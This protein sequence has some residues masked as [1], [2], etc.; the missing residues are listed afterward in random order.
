MASSDPRQKKSFTRLVS[1][2]YNRT[3]TGATTQ[4]AAGEIADPLGSMDDEQQEMPLTARLKLNGALNALAPGPERGYAV[5]AGREVLKIL[6]VTRESVTE[7]I[8][9]RVGSRLNLNFSSNDVAWGHSVTRSKIATAATNGAVVMWDYMRQG[10]KVDRIM[11]DHSRAVNR[12]RFDPVNGFLLV[13][14][15]Q[16]GTMKLWVRCLLKRSCEH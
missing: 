2:A 9:M 5:V 8:N 13:S 12:I 14:A 10:Q 15:S 1:Q 7:E 3:T 6:H 16:D 11:T 4:H